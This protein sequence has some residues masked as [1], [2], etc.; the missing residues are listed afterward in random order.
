LLLKP[1]LSGNLF[2]D[3][4]DDDESGVVG[5]LVVEKGW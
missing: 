4:D 3:D 2:D 5:W 1:H